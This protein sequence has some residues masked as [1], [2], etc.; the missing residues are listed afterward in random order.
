[1]RQYKPLALFVFVFFLPVALIGIAEATKSPKPE[2]ALQS[3]LD[4]VA[5]H[6]QLISN[7]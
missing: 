6:D 2:Y 5:A 1:M 4:A 7:H 3:D